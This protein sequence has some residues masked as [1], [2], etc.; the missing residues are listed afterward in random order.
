MSYFFDDKRVYDNSSWMKNTPSPILAK[1]FYWKWITLKRRT[2]KISGREELDYT[3]KN[4]EDGE[5]HFR[6]HL[7]LLKLVVQKMQ[8]IS[9]ENGNL[10][11]YNIKVKIEV[12]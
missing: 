4:S 3:C 7:N 8:K 9:S 10:I 5:T 2:K 12:I 1:W 6:T 11:T